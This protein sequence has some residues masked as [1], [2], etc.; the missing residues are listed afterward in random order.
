MI[1]SENL[2]YTDR[3]GATN[4]RDSTNNFLSTLKE[5]DSINSPTQAEDSEE[6]AGVSDGK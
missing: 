4:K 5:E 2:Y 6:T 1:L 3:N